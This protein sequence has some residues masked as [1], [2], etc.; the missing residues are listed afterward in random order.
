MRARVR[1]CG[2]ILTSIGS[3]VNTPVGMAATSA[4]E[5]G[6][7]GIP[8]RRAPTPIIPESGQSVSSNARIRANVLSLIIKTHKISLNF[9][10]R[11]MTDLTVLRPPLVADLSVTNLVSALSTVTAVSDTGSAFFILRASKV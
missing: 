5:Y 3:V 10:K 9:I 2:V 11:K 4:G 1:P 8:A 6:V 7:A